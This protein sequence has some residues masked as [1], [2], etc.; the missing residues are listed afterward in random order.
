MFEAVEREFRWPSAV[1]FAGSYACATA[2][3]L[4]AFTSILWLRGQVFSGAISEGIPFAVFLWVLECLLVLGVGALAFRF[5]P[6]RLVSH[7]IWLGCVYAVLSILLWRA[8]PRLMGV[9]YGLEGVLMHLV[10]R[11]VTLAVTVGSVHGLGVL[12]RKPAVHV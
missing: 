2:I 10:E 6:A 5:L 7:P 11:V 1:V 8:V 3:F 9:G 12:M 4:G